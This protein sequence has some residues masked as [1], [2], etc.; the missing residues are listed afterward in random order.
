MIIDKKSIYLFCIYDDVEKYL[1]TYQHVNTNAMKLRECYQRTVNMQITIQLKNQPLE[2]NSTISS[3][4]YTDK[5][6]ACE[7]RLKMFT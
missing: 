7:I 6:T 1:N 5:I 4:S 2:I 3:S